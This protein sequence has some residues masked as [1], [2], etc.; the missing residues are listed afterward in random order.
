MYG[1][2]REK[3]RK[4]VGGRWKRR[5]KVNRREGQKAREEE[6]EKEIYEKREQEKEKVEKTRNRKTIRR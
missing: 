2:K 1:R 3:G 4:G 5:E 6:N